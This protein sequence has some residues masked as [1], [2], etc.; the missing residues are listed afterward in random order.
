MGEGIDRTEFLVKDCP[1]CEGEGILD[2]VECDVCNGTEC[3]YCGFE[4]VLHN[5]PC[6]ECDARGEIEWHP[7]CST[8]NG[9]GEMPSKEFYLVD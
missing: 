4:G 2:V 7:R 6:P 8:C 1:E 3:E 5:V 9:S